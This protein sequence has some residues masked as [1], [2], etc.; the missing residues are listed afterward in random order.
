[1]TR[2]RQAIKRIDTLVVLLVAVL[3]ALA[4]GV[5]YAALYFGWF[6]SPWQ[7]AAWLLACAAFVVAG[8]PAV[9]QRIARNTHVHGAARPATEPEARAAARGSG[10]PRDIHEQHF[11]D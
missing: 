6:G 3:A 7:M 10:T 5:V 8:G 1:M 2:L 4:T 9:S 11:P